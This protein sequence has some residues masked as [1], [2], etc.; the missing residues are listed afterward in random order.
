MKKLLRG[1]AKDEKLKSKNNWKILTAIK[2]K[3][4]LCY[5]VYKVVSDYY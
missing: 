3:K 1:N 2:V 4:V 5:H